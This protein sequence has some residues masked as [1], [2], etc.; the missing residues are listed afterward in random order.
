MN[1]RMSNKIPISN[2]EVEICTGERLDAIAITATAFNGSAAYA[3]GDLV[4]Y[5][6]TG[7]CYE[8]IADTTGNLPTSEEFWLRHRIPAFLAE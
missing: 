4:Y 7:D 5:N 8:A 1:T 3:A 2:P 6:T